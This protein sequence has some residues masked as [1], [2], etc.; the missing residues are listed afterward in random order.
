M[1]ITEWVCACAWPM[2]YSCIRATMTFT[3]RVLHFVA[4]SAKIVQFL[5]VVVVGG[6]HV[7]DGDVDAGAGV[8]L[9]GIMS[10]DERRRCGGGRRRLCGT[11]RPMSTAVDQHLLLRQGQRHRSRSVWLLLLLLLLVVR[12][13]AWF[14][15]SKKNIYIWIRS[16]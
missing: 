4:R 6:G 7:G 11:R 9:F 10:R 13:S 12:G 5:V 15:K 16:Q 3:H 1:D 8:E 2:N 14:G